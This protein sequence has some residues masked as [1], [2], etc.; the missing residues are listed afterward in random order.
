MTVDDPPETDWR[1]ETA[2]KYLEARYGPS[3]W[4][5][6]PET[7]GNYVERW[8]WSIANGS[9]ELGE[10]CMSEIEKNLRESAK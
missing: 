4:F 5:R 8:I 1:Q 9:R 6:A 3:V 10:F 7:F 2:R